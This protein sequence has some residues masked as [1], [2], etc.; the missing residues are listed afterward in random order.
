MLGL[1]IFIKVKIEPERG[2]QDNDGVTSVHSFVETHSPP[3]GYLHRQ[4]ID[5][6]LF[7]QPSEDGP[8][9]PNNSNGEL[10]HPLQ[11]NP[12]A[13][14]SAS[15]LD[16]LRPPD[17]FINDKGVSNRDPLIVGMLGR[18]PSYICGRVR[19]SWK[20]SKPT[21]N[22]T[23][24]SGQWSS[25]ES[26][27]QPLQLKILFSGVL[28]VFGSKKYV[29]AENSFIRKAPIR[30][31]II[32]KKFVIWK[33]GSAEGARNAH[34]YPVYDFAKKQYTLLVPFKITIPDPVANSYVSTFALVSYSLKA[35][36]NYQFSSFFSNSLSLKTSSSRDLKIRRWP[37]FEQSENDT[38]VE[39]R[40]IGQQASQM[41]FVYNVRI[42]HSYYAGG[43]TAKIDL[44]V[45]PGLISLL[46]TDS[47][48]NINNV[49]QT[50][51]PFQS[52]SQ[53]TSVITAQSSQNSGDLPPMPPAYTVAAVNSLE[54]GVIA[55]LQTLDTVTDNSAVKPS[56]ELKRIIVKLVRRE[57]VIYLDYFGKSSSTMAEMS[58]DAPPYDP[59][60][61]T[62]KHTVFLTIPQ[63]NSPTLRTVAI[64]TNYFI[65]VTM[66][67]RGTSNTTAELPIKLMP[68]TRDERRMPANTE[69]GLPLCAQSANGQSINGGG[70]SNLASSAMQQSYSQGWDTAYVEP[71]PPYSGE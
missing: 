54:P 6:F 1:P 35:T 4:S 16:S 41:G 63:V 20:A 9:A 2:G 59:V 46:N 23:N 71:P 65:T 25:S 69:Y 13:T 39:A 22:S 62:Y 26:P 50:D 30:K 57:K 15:N 18:T 43:D 52:T 67:M 60:T 33:E 5:Q 31:N 40:S 7:D 14:R 66:V 61:K 21:G 32:D 44:C 48:N 8:V 34:I 28:Y 58:F 19:V 70:D 45:G 37:G 11:L 68:I 24:S 53:Q 29:N 36:L 38:S 56:V 17:Y 49:D 55:D 51:N 3:P 10:S 27:Y 64:H 47:N 42:P 12:Y